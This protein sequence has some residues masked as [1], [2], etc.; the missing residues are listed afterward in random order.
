MRQTIAALP[1]NLFINFKALVKLQCPS[2]APLRYTVCH[3]TCSSIRLRSWQLLVSFMPLRSFRPSFRF[4]TP[5]SQ[6]TICFK[7]WHTYLTPKAK[8]SVHIPFASQRYSTHWVPFRST[9]SSIHFS[10]IQ[11]TRCL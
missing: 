4:F 3:T 7:V 6:L 1:I 2:G 8:R 11:A 9:T 5:R 10:R